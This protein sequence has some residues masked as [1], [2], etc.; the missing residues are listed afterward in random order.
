MSAIGKGLDGAIGYGS[1]GIEVVTRDVS[2]RT[3]TLFCYDFPE[4]QCNVLI[5]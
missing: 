1:L 5:Y 2:A 3:M 4:M